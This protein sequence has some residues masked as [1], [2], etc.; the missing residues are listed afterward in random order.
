MI[1]NE[2][3]LANTR[4][5]S[6]ILCLY[7]NT[8][9]TQVGIEGDLPGVGVAW[10][11]KDGIL[12]ELI[13]SKAIRENGFEVKCLSRQDRTRSQDLV[14]HVETKEGRKLQFTPNK[15]GIHVLDCKSYFGAGKDG[16]LFGKIIEL[17]I[18]KAVFVVV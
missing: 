8:G 10:Q 4:K 17:P 13:Q 11:H 9:C 6:Q 5:L 2:Q 3:F 14:Y 18:I 15:K 16:C 1:V 12:N 7:T